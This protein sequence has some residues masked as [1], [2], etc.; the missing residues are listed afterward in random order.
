MKK[1]DEKRRSFLQYSVLATL[2]TLF[3]GLVKLNS[4][5][6]AADLPLLKESDPVAKSLGYFT[7]ADQVDTKKWPKRSGP[8][9]KQQ[10][11]STCMFYTAIDPKHGKCQIFPN[12]TVEAN[13]WCN[14]WS[15]KPA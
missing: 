13:A 6:Y 14:T 12:N 5:V 15:K 1:T 9:A 8:D 7:N 10:R 4:S 11:C 2:G 3:G